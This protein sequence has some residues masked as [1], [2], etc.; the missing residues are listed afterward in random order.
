M[1]RE[2]RSWKTIKIIYMYNA[3]NSNTVN[4]L[5]MLQFFLL[6][7]SQEGMYAFNKKGNYYY[8]FFSFLFFMYRDVTVIL[9]SQNAT[10]GTN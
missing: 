5:L 4:S 8:Y 7:F 6:S 1:R 10:G 9:F 3:H 2:R